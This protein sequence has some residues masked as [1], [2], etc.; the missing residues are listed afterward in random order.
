LIIKNYI[1]TEL[2]RSVIPAC[3]SNLIIKNIYK[4]EFARR[5]TE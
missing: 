5:I 1:I 4:R 3:K 2:F